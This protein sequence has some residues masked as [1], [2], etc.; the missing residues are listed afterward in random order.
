MTQTL[1][2]IFKKKIVSVCAILSLVLGI[3]VEGEKEKSVSLETVEGYLCHSNPK[4][5]VIFIIEFHLPFHFLQYKVETIPSATTLN[6]CLLALLKD[7]FD[8]RC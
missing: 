2:I 7:V 4:P 3:T 5:Y 1:G 8:P 6:C